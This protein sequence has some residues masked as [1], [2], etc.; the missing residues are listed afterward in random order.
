MPNFLRSGGDDRRRRCR[1]IAA[2]FSVCPIVPRVPTGCNV[3]SD[4]PLVGG[5]QNP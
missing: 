1:A 2:E 4:D 3:L 5:R